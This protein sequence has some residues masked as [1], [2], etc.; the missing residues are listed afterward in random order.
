MT[1]NIA[2][3][4]QGIPAGG[5]FAATAHAEP[6]VALAPPAPRPVETLRKLR[7][8]DFYPPAEEMAAWPALY[9]TDG[10]GPL[11]DK[12]LQAHYFQGGMDWY[13]A[14]YDPKANEAFGYVDLGHGGEWGYI[15]LAEVESVRGQS[16]LPIE[17]DLDFKP[18]TLA[19]ECIRKYKDEATAAETEAALAALLRDPSPV[20]GSSAED[21]DRDDRWDGPDEPDPL[22][23]EDRKQWDDMHRFGYNYGHAVLGV[24][25][26]ETRD[27]VEEFAGFVANAYM[28]SGWNLNMDIH[29]VVDDW[30]QQER[31]LG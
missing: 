5:Q 4:P 2:R 8:H 6:D 16:G 14:E 26:F 19:K 22:S 23:P 29:G 17:R 31:P 24:T 21:D 1:E 27:K 9:A 13:I 11:G 3:Q 10:E 25:G 18:G 7:G 30:M 20:E 12:P 28:E 15:D